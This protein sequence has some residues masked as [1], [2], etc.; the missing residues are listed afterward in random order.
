[1][2]HHRKVITIKPDDL[3]DNQHVNNVR[4]V[5]WVQEIAKEHWQNTVSETTQER[6]FWVVRNHHITY[7]ESAVL[8]DQIILTTE[9]ID[10]RGAIS[11]R[12]VEMKNHRTGNLLVKAT[13]DWCAVDSKNMRPTKIPE[14]I[15]QLFSNNN[16][17]LA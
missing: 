17:K 6:L 14:E 9:V 7:Y 11:V 4:Y 1:M 5:F 2:H 15:K 12:Q 13:T 3:D 8:G 16:E 10:W